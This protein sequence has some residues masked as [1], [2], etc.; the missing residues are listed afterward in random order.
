MGIVAQPD[1]F[2]TREDAMPPFEFSGSAL[3]H[4]PPEHVYA[5]IA[6]YRDGHTRIIPRPP[7]VSLEV[8][9]GGTGSGT[10]IR[11]GI[12]MFGKVVHYR[13]V[14]TEPEPGRV[15]VETNDNGYE[16]SFIVEPRGGGQHSHVTIATTMRWRGGIGGALE[17]W[18]MP[19]LLRPMFIR[20]LELLN[21]V[22][23][24][25]SPVVA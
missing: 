4:A 25:R 20:E 12:R 24:A 9:E 23:S 8:E 5:I 15:I 22:A 14:V 3:I 1:H 11:V 18:L 10:R 7:F 17:R 2:S 16:T 19:R 21:R 6:D 13:A